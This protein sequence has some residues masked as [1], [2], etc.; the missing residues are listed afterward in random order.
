MAYVVY[1]GK[2]GYY[3]NELQLPPN[4]IVEIEDQ[5]I[6]QARGIKNVIIVS[7]PLGYKL[8]QIEQKNVKILEEKNYGSNISK[9]QE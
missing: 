9:S 3:K 2:N 5:L 1:S 4:Q 6:N 8:T 7:I